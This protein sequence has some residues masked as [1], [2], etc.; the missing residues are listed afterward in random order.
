[1]RKLRNKTKKKLLLLLAGG[2][3]IGL[4][5][6]PKKAQYII[7]QIPKALRDFD[8]E[9]LHKLVKEFHHERLVDYKENNDGT[10]SI[11][12]TADGKSHSLRYSLDNLEIPVPSHW[13]KKWRLVL[14]DIPEKKR[15]GRDAL[16]LKLR[17]LGFYEWQK[18]AFIYPYPC[19]K[20]INFVVEVFDIRSYVRYAELS[21]L[22]NEAELKIK[23][24]LVWVWIGMLIT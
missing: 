7:R 1:M 19:E 5:R 14:F 12:L 22:T 3:S 2:V 9:H 24:K 11:I 21:S 16:R 20:E 18:S 8:K 10:V 6:S 15:K 13:D 23:F 4:S 17:E